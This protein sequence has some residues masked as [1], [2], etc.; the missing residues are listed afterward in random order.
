MTRTKHM[1]FVGRIYCAET[2]ARYDLGWDHHYGDAFDC[3][4][5]GEHVPERVWPTKM[6]R[7]TAMLTLSTPTVSAHTQERQ[8][9]YLDDPGNYLHV[10]PSE[11]W[12][13]RC[14]SRLNQPAT[15]RC[16]QCGMVAPW[17]RLREP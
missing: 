12:Y 10:G 14:G 1:R 8:R 3:P 11:N 13:C 7:A 16:D 15:W 5:C 4:G 9:A 17:L 6:S 2:K